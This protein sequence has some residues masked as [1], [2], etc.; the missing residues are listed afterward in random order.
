LMETLRRLDLTVDDLDA[1]GVRIYKVGLS[2][3]LET[4]R[5]DTFV[6]GR[7]CNNGRIN[8]GVLLRPRVTRAV[9]LRLLCRALPVRRINGGFL[10]KRCMSGYGKRGCD[11]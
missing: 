8:T 10:G 5:L 6:E 9:V 11:C 1:A 4:T 7:S 3:P 2:F